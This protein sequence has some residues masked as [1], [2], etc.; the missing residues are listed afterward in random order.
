MESDD[1]GRV[2]DKWCMGKR[3]TSFDKVNYRKYISMMGAL[4]S[5]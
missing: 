4:M 3:F 1:E 2:E 5:L